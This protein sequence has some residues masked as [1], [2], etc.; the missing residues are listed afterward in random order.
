M[1]FSVELPASAG[2]VSV[3]ATSFEID[4]SGTGGSLSDGTLSIGGY[5]W[6]LDGIGATS[7]LLNLYIR[8][9]ELYADYDGS[10]HS[11]EMVADVVRNAWSQNYTSCVLGRKDAASSGAQPGGAVGYFQTTAFYTVTSTT[12][13][14]MGC[15]SKYDSTETA[16]YTN[17]ANSTIDP[18][19]MSTICA[20]SACLATFRETTTGSAVRWNE[21]ASAANYSWVVRD[22]AFGTSTPWS[23]TDVIS[24]S[25]L[26][27]SGSGQ[28]T[29]AT[30]DAAGLTLTIGTS[31]VTLEKLY[32][33]LGIPEIP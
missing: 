2:A 14:F 10:K 9:T 22:A 25:L 3:P 8:P 11:V 5:D 23:T 16:S 24:F 32:V 1:P 29:T 17:L 31:S 7:T 20:G 33:Y 15:G 12:F 21:D 28:V 4:L 19:R 26:I 13:L 18:T 30:Q 6:N 27:Y